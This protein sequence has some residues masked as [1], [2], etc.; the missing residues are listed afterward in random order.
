MP[1]AKV[2]STLFR[3][4]AML[5]QLP[6]RTPG[7]SAAE[8]TACLAID[9]IPISKRSV[10]RDLNALLDMGLLECN[11]KGTPRGWYV[12][13]EKAQLAALTVAEAMSLSLLESYIKPLLPRALYSSVE[14]RF[15]QARRM[16]E[17]QPNF[18]HERRLMDL[19]HV[20]PATQALVPAVVDAQ[21][22]DQLQQALA[23][24]EKLRVSYYSLRAGKKRD[25]VLNPGGLFLRGAASF[26]VA[27]IDGR[28]DITVFA[29]HRIQSAERLIG[30]PVMLPSGFN[31]A[32]WLQNG[33]G[34]FDSR[35]FVELEMKVNHDLA[36][37]LME[38]PLTE[39]MSAELL[40]EH[41]YLIKARLLN[42]RQLRWW[43]MSQGDNLMVVNPPQLAQ[44][45]ADRHRAAAARYSSPDVS[46]P[47]SK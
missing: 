10:E 31:F 27:A 22:L 32:D 21:V 9:G 19:L 8:L 16:L 26:L 46:Q 39:N 24:G 18:N 4:L 47:S 3:Y 6:A 35:G 11:D 43:L 5:R 2:Q 34:D 36:R 15:R 23:K 29:V 38:T 20:V 45:V 37:I 44:W 25:F 30:E 28:D 42:T 7:M 41:E 12:R 1:Q 13:P 14:S 17:E 40:N 33:G